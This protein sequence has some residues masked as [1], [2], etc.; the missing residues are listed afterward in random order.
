MIKIPLDEKLLVQDLRDLS[1][2]S[3]HPTMRAVLALLAVHIPELTKPL[4]AIASRL[5]RP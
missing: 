4:Q 2:V 5:V 3:D 1:L